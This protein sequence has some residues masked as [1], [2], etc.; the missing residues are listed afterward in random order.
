[1]R[2]RGSPTFSDMSSILCVSYFLFLAVAFS[3][4]S[5]ISGTA[6][7]ECLKQQERCQNNSAEFF[8]TKIMCVLRGTMQWG[9]ALCFN[10]LLLASFV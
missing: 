1:M 8:T 4:L 5:Y 7:V 3:E 6:D 2:R 9:S 10:R